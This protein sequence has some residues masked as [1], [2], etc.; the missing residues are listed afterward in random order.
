MIWLLPLL[1]LLIPGPRSEPGQSTDLFSYSLEISKIQI[2]FLVEIRLIVLDG[3][4][5]IFYLVIVM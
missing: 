3:S 4:H 1:R 2:D 5:S